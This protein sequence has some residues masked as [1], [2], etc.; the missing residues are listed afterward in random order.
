MLRIALTVTTLALAVGYAT[1]GQGTNAEQP[2]MPDLSEVTGHGPR[3]EKVMSPALFRG[4]QAALT[5]TSMGTASKQTRS[6]W[7]SMAE[8]CGR[9]R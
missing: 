1:V 7:S 2:G 3:L 6:A 8:S 5:P 9:L 4:I